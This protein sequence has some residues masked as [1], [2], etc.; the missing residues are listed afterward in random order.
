M[1]VFFKNKKEKEDFDDFSLE[2]ERKKEKK[3]F[4]RENNEKDYNE[5]DFKYEE[6]INLKFCCA[7]WFSGT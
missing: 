1:I 3:L 4:D 5:N 6:N 7:F 2:S